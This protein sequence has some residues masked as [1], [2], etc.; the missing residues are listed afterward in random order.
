MADTLPRSFAWRIRLAGLKLQGVWDFALIHLARFVV[1]LVQPIV[2]RVERA[3][4]KQQRAQTSTMAALPIADAPTARRCRVDGVVAPVSGRAAFFLVAADG[5]RALV[6]PAAAAAVWCGKSGGDCALLAGDRVAVI[7]VA[8][9]ADPRIDREIDATRPAR[10]VFA[11]SEAEPLFIV[12]LAAAV[13]PTG[14]PYR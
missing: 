4:L 3:Q 13:A 5:Q 1:F 11:G 8:R 6:Q 14:G 2:K 9:A 12:R 7:G 10:L